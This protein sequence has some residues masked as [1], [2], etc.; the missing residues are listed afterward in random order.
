ML[1]TYFQ[2]Q[3]VGFIL[4]SFLTLVFLILFM[5]TWFCYFFF[6]FS[7][8]IWLVALTGFFFFWNIESTLHY[9]DKLFLATVYYPLY[10]LLSC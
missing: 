3:I 4:D 9:R 7:L 8:L 1:D 6:F 2:A 10:I 5:I